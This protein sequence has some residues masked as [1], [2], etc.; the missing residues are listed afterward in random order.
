MVS[1]LPD[2][3]VAQPCNS[4]GHRL[5][6]ERVELSRRHGEGLHEGEN[7]QPTGDG[8]RAVQAPGHRQEGADSLSPR[9][10]PPRNA[11]TPS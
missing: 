8:R 7:P 2:V 4:S 5:G 9:P 11:R 10:Q 6:M 1:S 3:R